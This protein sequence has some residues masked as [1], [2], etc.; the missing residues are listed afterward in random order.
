MNILTLKR[1][2]SN[3][4]ATFG[5][6]ID[7]DAKVPFCLTLELPWKDNRPNV[8]CIPSGE[9]LAKKTVRIR[10]G[11]TYEILQVPNRTDVL[12]HKGNFTSETLGCILLGESFEDTLSKDGSKIATGVMSS[13]KAY[14]EF[15]TR[16]KNAE[17]FKLVIRNA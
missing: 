16:L 17:Y 12:I 1:V 3:D 7:E 11:L 5:V 2:L 14:S 9:Y 8:S 10:F 4:E 13:G 6:M 15:I